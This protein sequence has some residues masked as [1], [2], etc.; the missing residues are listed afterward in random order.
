M[1]PPWIGDILNRPVVH[2]IRWSYT[3]D[4][5]AKDQSKSAVSLKIAGH[6]FSSQTPYSFSIRWSWASLNPKS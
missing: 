4:R 3:Q 5:Q 6:T 1:G 2:P